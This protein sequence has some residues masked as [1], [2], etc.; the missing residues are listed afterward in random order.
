LGI[1]IT[2]ALFA[3]HEIRV[4]IGETAPLAAVILILIDLMITGLCL[5]L[6]K[7]EKLS[8]P[9]KARISIFSGV[10]ILVMNTGIV[11]RYT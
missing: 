3:S 8:L 9:N 1:G 7:F 4:K 5:H 10:V 2:G 6:R 11:W